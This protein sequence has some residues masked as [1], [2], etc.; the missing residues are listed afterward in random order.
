MAIYPWEEA[1]LKAAM[2][3]KPALLR[4][5]IVVARSAI[6]E[7]LNQVEKISLE[8]QVEI[9]NALAQ[10]LRIERERC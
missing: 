2:E 8:E 5:R 4:S 7:R 1:C 10:L 9:K 6:Y 3:T